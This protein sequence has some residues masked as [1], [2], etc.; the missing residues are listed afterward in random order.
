MDRIIDY[1]C[2]SDML[3]QTDT[4]MIKKRSDWNPNR[5][6]ID[7]EKEERNKSKKRNIAT[8]DRMNRI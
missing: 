5:I 6:S 4:R 7:L 3:I 2:R 1:R 8:H